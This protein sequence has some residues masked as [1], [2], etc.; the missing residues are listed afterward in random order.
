MSAMTVH[1]QS[2][3]QYERFDDVIGFV[4]EDA[5]G[6]FGVLPGHEPLLTCLEFGL[7][8]FR[9]AAGELH[10]IAVPGAVLRFAGNELHVSARRYLRD[11]D[12]RRIAGSLRE[13]L[14]AEE[15]K[16][17]DMKERLRRLET[18]MLR[19]LWLAQR[20]AGVAL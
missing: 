20:E 6:F 14:A 9:T 8:R 15:A 7:A 4:G 10:Y 11:R 2:A 16:L 17:A 13:D 3:T 18:E 19:R 5:S 12:Y 1:L